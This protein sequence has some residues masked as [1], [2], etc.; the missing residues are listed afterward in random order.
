VFDA[1]CTTKK[2]GTGLGLPIVK[3]LITLQDGGIELRRRQ[4][5]G[6]VAEISIPIATPIT[7][8][9]PG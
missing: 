1:F 4:G 7:D 2:G 8:A 9:R 3:R 5:G 6:T